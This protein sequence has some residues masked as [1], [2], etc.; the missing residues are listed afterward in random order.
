M[1]RNKIIVQIFVV[2]R[3]VGGQAIMFID[4]NCLKCIGKSLL[5]LKDFGWLGMAV[6]ENFNRI[7]WAT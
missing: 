7:P 3:A 6:A 2:R 5:G 4:D 1:F